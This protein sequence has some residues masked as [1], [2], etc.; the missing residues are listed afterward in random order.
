MPR[1]NRQSRTGIRND[2]ED[3]EMDETERP[4]EKSHPT[5]PVVHPRCFDGSTPFED[6]LAH[7][8]VVSKVNVWDDASKSLFLPVYLTGDAAKKYNMIKGPF[9]DFKDLCDL[10]SQNLYPKELI[11]LNK[12]AFEAKIREPGENLY[13]LG[14]DIRVM[15]R[16]AYPS[17]SDD[18]ID[19]ISKEQFIKSLGNC[20]LRF[21]VKMAK[22]ENL[23]DSIRQSLEIEAL[24]KAETLGAKSKGVFSLNENENKDEKKVDSEN[25]LPLIN[26]NM[27]LMES[28]LNVMKEVAESLKE[29][30]RDRSSLTCWFCN[31]RG[32]VKSNCLK[33]KQQ[34]NK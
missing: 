2:S 8:E 14:Q 21:L 4:R 27:K 24:I 33:F 13:K 31:Q 34:E 20:Q 18:F 12:I 17:D 28:S 10:L 9:K 29:L 16:R 26:Q 11:E 6:W 25:I 1:R 19:R 23:E 7:F 22:P 5:K 32:H 15:A 3:R 30:R